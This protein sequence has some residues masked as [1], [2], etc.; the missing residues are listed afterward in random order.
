MILNQDRKSH[1]VMGAMTMDPSDAAAYW[2]L[3][4]LVSMCP[5]TI[6]IIT[7]TI[8]NLGLGM[9]PINDALLNVNLAATCT[10]HIMVIDFPKYL[11]HILAHD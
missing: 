10:C 1:S 2:V 6:Y 7:K 9:A 11:K 8:S 4:S 3:C 5:P